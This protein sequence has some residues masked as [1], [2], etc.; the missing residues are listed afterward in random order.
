MS[1]R[2]PHFAA[3]IAALTKVHHEY[4]TVANPVPPAAVNA[5][6]AAISAAL[7]SDPTT[8]DCTLQTPPAALVINH[9]KQTRF[10]NAV[11]VVVNKA[12]GGGLNT[13]QI[14]SG[15]DDAAGVA[16]KP[17]VIDT[18]YARASAAPPIVGTVCSCTSG[19]WTGSPTAYAYQWKR[20]GAT[21]LGTAASYTLVAA[22]VGGH[23][24]T[25]VVTATNATGSQAAPPS[26]A[27]ST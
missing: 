3:E 20:D 22:D 21:S 14:I 4:K 19:N 18:P 2:E 27:I 13:S 12:K 23:L 25:C 8:H 9:D 17:A 11:L 15:I 5:E 10:T 26:N 1:Y 24:I 6:L 7:A 16:H